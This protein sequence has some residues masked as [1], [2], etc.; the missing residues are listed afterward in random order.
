MSKKMYEV[1]IMEILTRRIEVEA[2]NEEEA[3]EIINTKYRD[4]DIVLD[5][6][7]FCTCEISAV[8]I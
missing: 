2:N 3:V 8:E 5:Y 6:N 7:D 1:E 4:G